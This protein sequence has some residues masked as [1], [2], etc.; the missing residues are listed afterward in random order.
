MYINPDKMGPLRYNEVKIPREWI[1]TR[2]RHTGF[3]RLL[4]FLGGALSVILL[5]T[6]CYISM[7]LTMA[8]TMSLPGIFRIID[9]IRDY[10]S[11]L[12]ESGSDD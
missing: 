12:Y 9:T 1:Y 11:S 6:Q 8:A 2:F 5:G 3:R 4:L 10:R 7:A